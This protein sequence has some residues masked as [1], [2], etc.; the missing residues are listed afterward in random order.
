MLSA[1]MLLRPLLAGG[2][3]RSIA[4]APRALAIV[5]ADPARIPDLAAL[6]RDADP[7]IVQRALDL[8]EKLAHEHPDWI[9]PHKRVFIGPLARDERWEVRL[10][11]VRA[12]ALFSWSPAERQRVVAILRENAGHPQTFVRVWALDS[13]SILAVDDVSLRSYV[14]RHLR[15]FDAS[16]SKALAARARH[17]RARLRMTRRPR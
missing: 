2:D 4:R 6:T 5:R 9:R 1:S 8:L 17:I 15:R 3:R 12:L 7:L 10:Q 13:L 14:R 11:V 16:G